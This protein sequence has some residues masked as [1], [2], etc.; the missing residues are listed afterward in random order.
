MS[1]LDLVGALSLYPTSSF[2]FL[3]TS[4]ESFEKE[5][6]APA[7]KG[8]L[9]L[10]VYVPG[11]EPAGAAGSHT[12]NNLP[13]TCHAA[14]RMLTFQYYVRSRLSQQMIKRPGSKPLPLTTL[15]WP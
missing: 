11:V 12:C 10:E 6:Q 8:D 3:P 4:L 13:C 15:V 7:R 14:F 2:N 1:L 5:L 9:L